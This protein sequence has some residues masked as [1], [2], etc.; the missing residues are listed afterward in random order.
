MNVF[1]SKK[2]I[3]F[4]PGNDKGNL[5][6]SIFNSHKIMDPWS[7][8]FVH[9]KKFL[10]KKKVDIN[11]YDVPTKKSP[12][13]YVYSDLPYPFP[14]NFSLWKS[15]FLNRQRNILICGEPPTVIPF[16]Y[17]KIFHLFFKKVYTWNDDLV[18]DKKYFK[19]YPP[20]HTIG[21]NT[22]PKQFKEKKF[23][24]LI[25]A[26]KSPFYPFE[27]LSSFG[28][29]LYSERVKAIDFFEKIIP[30][31]FYL[32][33]RGWNK[34]RKFDLK[35]IVLGFKK[36]STYKGELKF[37]DKI[38]VLSNFKYCICF[39]N[40]TG[41]PGYITEK[42]FD[43]FKAKSVPIYWGASDIEKYIPKDCFIDFR[44][45]ASYEDLLNFLTSI[46]EKRYNF[47]IENIEKL[48][49]DKKFISQWFEVGFSK[50]FLEHV[51]EIKQ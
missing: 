32:Y 44:D 30:E 50:F 29:E 20:K 42:L 13:W 26:N 46:D 35:D 12:D 37:D 9:L 33:G 24:T 51:L 2:C 10:K 34:P 31:D 6:N 21:I 45:F 25:N 1:L 36:K 48:L 7:R 28:K 22:P 19:F 49:A 23:L 3:I 39:E 14:S 18:D 40:L 27:L 16:N 5:R 15:I 43:C 17:M 4:F 8:V 11:T 41:V 38:K 47:Y